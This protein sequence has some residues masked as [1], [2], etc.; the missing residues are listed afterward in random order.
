ML[1]QLHTQVAISHAPPPDKQKL[2]PPQVPRRRWW[3]WRQ[4]RA[5]DAV[6]VLTVADMKTRLAQQD[7]ELAA[8]K[9][10]ATGG[11]EGERARQI[12]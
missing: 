11:A 6:P 3:H 5:R 2:V 1:D 7:Q 8:L 12:L 9:K 10:A 4:S